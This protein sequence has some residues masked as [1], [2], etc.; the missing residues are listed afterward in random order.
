MMRQRGFTLVEMLVSILLFSVVSLAMVTI[1]ATATNLFRLG[2]A[3]RAASDEAMAT[4]TAFD[5]DL[6]QIV[7]AANGGFWFCQVYMPNIRPA[8]NMVIAFVIANP[9][10]TSIISTSGSGGGS[11]PPNHQLT[12]SRQL[13]IWWV[14]EKARLHRVALNDKGTNRYSAVEA[15][16][17]TDHG[18]PATVYATGCLY[19]G[20]NVSGPDRSSEVPSGTTPWCTEHILNSAPEAFP[21]SVRVRMIFAGATRDAP[22]GTVIQDDGLSGIRISGIKTLPGGTGALV[23]IGDPGNPLHT[24]EWISYSTFSKGYLRD[25]PTLGRKQLRTDEPPGGRHARNE[26]VVAGQTYSLTRVLNH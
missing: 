3:G 17:T 20:V 11:T 24:P 5:S 14:D 18:D 6:A 16:V 23:R 26:P 13:V 7:P 1:L 8:G 25:D 4:L 12:M 19:L 2:E 21:D 15:H 10:P 9:D 22:K